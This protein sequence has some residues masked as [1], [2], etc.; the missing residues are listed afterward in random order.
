MARTVEIENIEEKRRQVGID[1]VELREEIRA[2]KVGDA[3]KLTF[4]SS[5]GASES[6][7]VRITRIRG[8]AFRGKL[9]KRALAIPRGTIVEFTIAHV[10]SLVNGQAVHE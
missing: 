5:T 9:V 1:D 8:T 10:H 4:M 7:P 2:L 3:V 6:V